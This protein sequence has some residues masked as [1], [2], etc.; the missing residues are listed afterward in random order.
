MGGHDL[1]AALVLAKEHDLALLAR[2]PL[3]GG[4]LKS[5]D[6]NDRQRAVIAP[7]DTLA[8]GLGVSRTVATTA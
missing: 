5:G 6:H 4:R 2:S 8:N 7:L 3:A 1:D